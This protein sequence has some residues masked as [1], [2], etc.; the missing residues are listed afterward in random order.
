[1]T[2]TVLLLNMAFVGPDEGR[3]MS[4]AR[5]VLWQWFA[6]ATGILLGA[7][8]FPMYSVASS[9]AFDR[10]D[11][12]SLLDVSTTLLVLNSIGSIAGPFTVM[13]VSNYLG[14]SALGVSAGCACLLV[15]IVTVYRRFSA[16]S[17]A[18]HTPSMPIPPTSL[19]MAKAV[20]ELAGPS[21]ADTKFREHRD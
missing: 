10:A 1:M 8:V 2:A 14:D 17:P 4:G 12:D 21:S 7:T 11:S 5:G 15:A 16:E 20:A 9:L 13:F 6:F 19:E 3:M 18:E